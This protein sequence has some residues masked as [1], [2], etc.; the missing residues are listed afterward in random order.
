MSRFL[1]IAGIGFVWSTFAVPEQA[2]AQSGGMG[3]RGSRQTMFMQRSQTPRA[4]QDFSVV[5][6]TS[7]GKSVSGTLNLM[8]VVVNYDL[9]HYEIEPEK[10]KEIHFTAPKLEQ[11]MIVGPGGA[12]VEGTIITTTGAEIAGIVMV[13]NWKLHTDLGILTLDAQGLKSL[14]FKGKAPEPPSN[15]TKPQQAPAP[16]EA[17]PAP[18]ETQSP[19]DKK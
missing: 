7:G 9:G 10:V 3:T 18:I 5:V 14:S 6:A 12:M 19:V 13:D 16:P 17:K 4:S 11:M 1:I 15:A 8:W 2:Q